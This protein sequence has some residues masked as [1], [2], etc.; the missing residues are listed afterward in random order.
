MEEGSEDEIE[1]DNSTVIENTAPQD[2][3]RNIRRKKAIDALKTLLE[4]FARF[5]NPKN[6]KRESELKDIYNELLK[7]DQDTLR[8][9][10]FYCIVAYRYSFLAPYVDYF[11]K[12]L[13]SKQFREG[14]VLF[15]ISD[16][17]SVVQSGHREELIPYLLKIL[18]G[19]LSSYVMVRAVARRNAVLTYLRGF[20]PN[21]LQLFFEI[22][23]GP[24]LD[25]IKINEFSTDLEQLCESIVTN[26]D[27][28]N[29]LSPKK[30]KRLVY[31]IIILHKK[32]VINILE[33]SKCTVILKT[34]QN[35]TEN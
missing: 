24:L 4:T 6:I 10:A 9:A 30:L 16:E 17:N 11:A 13:D 23:F 35:F 20:Q 19:S 15:S 34:R 7:C 3:P 8:T 5:S 31:F 14:L 29:T 28:S 32:P 26:Y 18:Y 2:A 12:L 1:Q 27:S 25:Y 21:E 33:N 22:M